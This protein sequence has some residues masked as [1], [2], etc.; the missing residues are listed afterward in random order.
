MQFLAK[1]KEKCLQIFPTALSPSEPASYSSKA[2]A[3]PATMNSPM[4]PLR[5]NSI[6]SSERGESSGSSPKN[7]VEVCAPS[8][9]T[10]A[11]ATSGDSLGV[12]ASSSR[13]LC[14]GFSVVKSVGPYR[15]RMA[16]GGC[17]HRCGCERNQKDTYDMFG[18]LTTIIARCAP[19]LLPPTMTFS[20]AASYPRS[21]NLTDNAFRTHCSADLMS[22]NCSS[23]LASGR[24]R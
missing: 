1:Q 11:S 13:R 17:C 7:P 3:K 12:S 24:R 4:H 10:A 20:S 21:L 8:L 23:M 14:C 16:R 6:A 19:A 2:S 22:S 9:K 18:Q 15:A 5:Y